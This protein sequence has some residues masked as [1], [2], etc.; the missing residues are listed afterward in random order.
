MKLSRLVSA[1]AFM[2]VFAFGTAFAAE[3]PAAPAAPAEPS[4]PG[5]VADRP[6]TLTPYLSQANLSLD[7][8]LNKSHAAKDIGLNVGYSIG[9]PHDIEVGA[10]VNALSYSG[11]RKDDIGVSN[12]KFGGF[13]VYGRWAF[14]PIV[15]LQLDVFAPGDRYVH[16][17]IDKFGDQRLGASVGLPVSYTIIDNHLAV[18]GGVKADLGFA[19]KTTGFSK[20]M[21]LVAGLDAGLTYNLMKELYFDLSTGYK[22]QFVPSKKA[23]DGDL[24]ER[25]RLP[26]SITAGSTLLADKL[27]VG[28]TFYTANLLKSKATGDKAF[29]ARGLLFSGSYRF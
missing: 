21:Q 20:D 29:A 17:F 22:A 28:L 13:D 7:L 23:V 2:G 16:N 9:L 5:I 26:L 11:Y 25:S 27:D 10:T 15:G 14:N 8:G 18:H 12:T 19:K 4:Y 1:T 3:T 6:L 24:K